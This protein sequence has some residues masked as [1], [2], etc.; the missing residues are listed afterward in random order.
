MKKKILAL[1]LFALSL[2]VSAQVKILEP[3]GYVNDFANIIPD[4]VEQQLEARLRAYEQQTTIEFAVVT[5]QSL[6]GLVIEDYSIQLAEKWRVGKKDKDNGV[7]LLIAVDDKK[8]RL[9][10]GYGLEGD[11]PDITCQRILDYKIV[12]YFKKGD[13]SGGIMAGVDAVI[14]KLGTLSPE[15]RLEQRKEKER[16]QKEAIKKAGTVV[17]AIIIFAA[18]IVLVVILTKALIKK[19]EESRKIRERK[20]RAK[21]NAPKLVEKAVKTVEEVRKKTEEFRNKGFRVPEMRETKINAATNDF[22]L[23][24]KQANAVILYAEGFLEGIVDRVNLR[25]KTEKALKEI[26]EELVTLKKKIPAANEN[27]LILKKDNPKEVWTAVEG[28]LENVE[29]LSQTLF[30][31]LSQAKQL[32]SMD[33]QEFESADAK[34]RECHKVVDEIESHIAAPEEILKRIVEAKSSLNSLKSTFEGKVSKA[35]KLVKNSDV[36]QKAKSLLKEAREK[37]REANSLLG[38]KLI[39]WLLVLLLLNKALELADQSI[40]KANQDIE[41]AEEE[42]RRKRRRE[43]ESRRSSYHG[44]TW[45]SGSSGSSGGGFGGFGGGSFG[46]GGASSGW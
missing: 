12:P 9:E 11:L 1:G 25:D 15:E 21:E 38:E 3:Y 22:E 40:K 24:C 6:E 14:E 29:G 23:V 31:K 44:S 13:Y 33:K 8:L 46:G 32:N 36:E 28:N 4:D 26:P 45:S 39:N 42:R 16:R 7:I 35:E 27:L 2:L 17:L 43:E 37:L 30:S 19:I 18:F 10:V 5:I 41:E 34:I 20:R